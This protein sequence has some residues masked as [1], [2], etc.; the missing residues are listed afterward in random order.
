[1]TQIPNFE[2]KLEWALW[3]A[4]FGFW[5]HP[6]RIEGEKFTAYLKGKAVDKIAKGKEPR[7]NDWQLQATRD[8]NQIQ[9]WWA[10]NP[11]YN[12]GYST[13][14]FGDDE[15]L[16]VI[17]IDSKIN[18]EIGTNGFHSVLQLELDG[19]DFPPTH[20]QRTPSGGAHWIYRSKTPLRQGTTG[21]FGFGVDVRASG[22][23][24]VGAGSTIRGKTYTFI[25]RNLQYV[26]EWLARLAARRTAGR[27]KRSLTD[28]KAIEQ[29]NQPYAEK[30]AIEYLRSL[31]TSIEGEGH[32]SLLKSA[33]S[34]RDFGISSETCIS[35][36]KTHWKYDGKELTSDF[37]IERV[38]SGA[39]QSA[40]DVV[41]NKAPEL[42]FSEV[43]AKESSELVSEPKSLHPFEK[44]NEE[45]AFVMTG[46]GHHILWNTK[47]VD[48]K[49][50]L[51][52]LREETFHK[53]F[54]AQQTKID[55]KM[56]A[57]S[58]LWMQSA[59]RRS[60]DGLCFK[61]GVDVGLRWYNLWRGFAVDPV[62][63]KAN[64]PS[65]DAFL[66][67]ARENVCH[68]NQE[69][70]RWLIGYFAHLVQHPGKKPQTALV[71]KGKKGVGKSA[72]IDRIGDLLPRY[73]R[74]VAN[75]RYLVGNFN[76]HLE[77][78][79]LLKCEEA[80]WSGDKDADSILKDLITGRVH[81][82][83]RK[84][85]E[86]YEIE[87]LTRVCILGNEDWIVPATDDERR[88]A[89]FA[90]GE[91][92]KQDHKFFEEMRLGMEQGGYAHLL[93]Y[94]LDFDITGLNFNRAPETDALLD[95][96]MATLDPFHQW[97]N[98]CL[99]EG[100]LLYGDF[101]EEWPGLART[102]RVRDAFFAYLRNRQIRTRHPDARQIGV[103]FFRCLPSLHVGNHR[104]GKG[105]IRGYTFPDLQ[106]SRDEWDKFIGH[107]AQWATENSS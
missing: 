84:G 93:R 59:D 58:R 15:M 33:L 30:R 39:Y 16:Y 73:Y 98:E 65:V 107:K 105:W 43:H 18:K 37:E 66:E 100:K 28:E 94:L 64:H 44:F 34:I 61:P 22:G 54:A 36:I 11:D 101:E 10:E 25:G 14:K 38:V 1:M 8:R 26:P 75:R 41:G 82:I 99:T 60:Y 76:S 90:V 27:P 29:I 72:L 6:L 62:D 45:F 5:I 12:I 40:F 55:G 80:F 63:E 57:W 49:P 9:R 97:W 53:K 83:E 20:S 68:G 19:K 4:A 103:M 51:Q 46:G 50:E 91:A 86:P 3:A 78:C 88:Y 96:K 92:R 24:L 48:G 47:D 81:N 42:Q 79:I 102:D 70:F 106:S 17:D 85:Q 71:F 74:S 89:V 67:H 35:L 87:N 56:K 77:N 32:Q 13:S 23:N 52:H 104:S 7:L 21:I 31:P 95:Q 2:T 69:H